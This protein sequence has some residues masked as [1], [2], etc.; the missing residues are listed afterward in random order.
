MALE[1][2]GE[3][4]K[5]GIAPNLIAYNSAIKACEDGG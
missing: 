3:M 1:L 5:K 4:E 2:L